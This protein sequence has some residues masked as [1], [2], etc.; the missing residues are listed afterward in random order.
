MIFEP[1]SKIG[2]FSNEETM[3]STRC[4]LSRSQL[5]NGNRQQLK[6]GPVDF[7]TATPAISPDNTEPELPRQTWSASCSLLSFQPCMTNASKIAIY[8]ISSCVEPP[9][10]HRLKFDRLKTAHGSAS[11]ILHLASGKAPQSLDLH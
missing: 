11:I 4:M 5:A 10:R 3:L 9:V 7:A 2:E 1:A 8:L 6:H